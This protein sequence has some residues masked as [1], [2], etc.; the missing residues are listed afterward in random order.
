MQQN[1]DLSGAPF[2]NI[3]PPP[4]QDPSH[5]QSTMEDAMDTANSIHDRSSPGFALGGEEEL[6]LKAKKDSAW[7]REP[8][9]SWNNRKAKEEYE[10][11]REQVQNRD[12][13]LAEFGDLYEDMDQSDDI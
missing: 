1:L 8:G 13:S 6:G 11:T 7:E 3:S 10:R 12:F 4:S 5:P 2:A 9:W